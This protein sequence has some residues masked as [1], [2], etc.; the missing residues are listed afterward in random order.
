VRLSLLVAGLATLVAGAPPAPTLEQACGSTSG[1]RAQAHW[2]RT[3][4]GVRLFMVEAGKGRTTIVL[5]HQGGDSLCGELPYAKTLVSRGFRIVAFD[6][7][8]W[9]RSES[10][11][12]HPLALGRDLAAAVARARAQGARHVFLIGASM[13]G[14]AV[15]Q[16]SGSLRV[17]GLVSL[18]G[19][20]LWAGFG[21]NKPGPAALRAPF[22]YLGSKEDGRAP[23][24]EA[25]AIVA[26]AGSTDKR[27][28]FYDGS[29]H[30]WGLVQD[31]PF[32]AAARALIL[33]WVGE[34][35]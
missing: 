28:F 27:S 26:A 34:R 24:A 3:S 25:E 31:A 21:V 35:A 11:R 16:N 14:A 7:R 17:D 1:L 30:G 2:L 20:R 29:F 12:A 18:S 8:G 32:A 9:G 23:L 4:D 5:A 19:T 13:G 22:L 6:F 15:V 10:S 33:A